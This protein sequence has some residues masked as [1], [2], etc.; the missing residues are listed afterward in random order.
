MLLPTRCP[1]GS[2]PT[3]GP[4]DADGQCS[5]DQEAESPFCSQQPG[6]P[7]FKHTQW[8]ED[9]AELLFLKKILDVLQGLWLALYAELQM[10][11]D[12]PDCGRGSF[13]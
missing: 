4:D 3:C 6:G 10:L 5:D 11:L 9:V 13:C 12:W 2:E 7:A 1:H 8:H